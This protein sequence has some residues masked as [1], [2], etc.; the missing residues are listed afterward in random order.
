MT[1]TATP[2]PVPIARCITT[3]A[4]QQVTL[5]ALA[6]AM[7]RV[8]MARR[9]ALLAEVANIESELGYGT[10]DKPTTAQIREAWRRGNGRDRV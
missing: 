7:V 1:Q 9:D 2:I 6:G 10:P 5:D 8:L 3:I 4:G